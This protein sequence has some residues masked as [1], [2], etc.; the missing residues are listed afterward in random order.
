MAAG[1]KPCCHRQGWS[2]STRATADLESALQS[3]PDI[4]VNA[5]L[6]AD[7]RAR[8]GRPGFQPNGAVRRIDVH[9]QRAVYTDLHDCRR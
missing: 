7:K 5:R 4:G 1:I 2:R 9:F 3:Q 8:R 6:F